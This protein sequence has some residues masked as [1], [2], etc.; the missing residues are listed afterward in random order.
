MKI[1]TILAA[2]GLGMCLTAG[3]S[4]QPVSAAGTGIVTGHVTC[5]DTQRPARLA[6]ITLLGVPK[7]TTQMPKVDANADPEAMMAAVRSAMD[8]LKNTTMVSTQTDMNGAF[9]AENVAPGDYY[10]FAAKAGYVQP[11]N[12]VQAALDAGADPHKLLPGI[13]VVHVVAEH[14]AN[15]EV[16]IDRGAA[17]SGSAQFDD[18]TPVTGANVLVTPAKTDTK[19]PPPEFAMLAAAGGLSGIFSMTDD[20]GHFRMSGLAP[21]EYVVQIVLPLKNLMNLTAGSFNFSRMMAEKPLVAYA[22]AALHKADAKTIK[23]GTGEDKRDVTVTFNLNGMHTVSGRV[24]SLEDH[25]GLNAAT[26]TVTDANDKD[27]VRSAGVDAAG[28]FTVTFV[29][30]G[31]YALK[32]TNAGDTEPAR[33][34]DKEKAALSF[35]DEHTLKSYD[36]I[37]QSLIVSDGDVAGLDIE[38]K[39]SKTVKKDLNLGDM[40]P[41]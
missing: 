24:A 34:D 3:W 10:I 40:L 19:Q 28:N 9:V 23:L 16:T 37:Q 18:G 12:Q 30:A 13:P 1:T 39:T 2:A 27:F 26:V 41:Q 4:Q 8:S 21:G 14:T 7:E 38:L 33:K 22:P 25:H 32:V 29:P 31:T 35:A 15:A 20:L 17:V 11:L 36:D 6:N 5:G